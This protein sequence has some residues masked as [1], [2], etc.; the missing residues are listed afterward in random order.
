MRTGIQSKLVILVGL[1][2]LSITATVGTTFYVAS[3]Q[4]SDAA[5][6][7]VAA[8]QRLLAT[9][10]ESSSRELIDALE[11]ESSSEDIKSRLH[12]KMN[13][14]QTSLL[15]LKDGGE[16]FD[17][18]GA[19]IVFPASEGDAHQQL[20]LVKE[21]WSMYKQ[22]LDVL[23]APEVDVTADTFY[24]ALD[25]A[26]SQ[27]PLVQ[28]KSGKAISL[29]KKDSEAKVMLLKSVLVSALVAIL[30][31]AVLAWIYVRRQVVAPLTRLAHTMRDSELNSNLSL[32]IAPGPQDEIG[33]TASNFNR[34]MDKFE[35]ILQQL[36][37]Y[38]A[39]VDV[40][41]VELAKVANR[42]EN[43]VEKQ[44]LEID[45][46]AIAMNE[47]Q[48]SS[49][50]VARN[51]D[52]AAAKANEAQ[53]AASYSD[54]VV[55]RTISAVQE[56]AHSTQLSL[57]LMS[58]LETDVVGIGAI[59]DVIRGIADQ[60][61]LLA[62]NAA[63]EAA[64]AGEQGRGF[65]VVADEVRMLAQRTQNSTQEIQN[66]IEQLQA[67]AT[68]AYDA[69][70]QG[71][72]HA[73]ETS[74]Q[75]ASTGESL[76]QIA[77]VVTEIAGMNQQISIASHQQGTVAIELDRNLSQIKMGA[78]ESADSSQK[79]TAAGAQLAELAVELRAV[80]SQFRLSGPDGR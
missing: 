37:H 22:A 70:N 26:A 5:I 66:M 4:F 44:Q 72:E 79:T 56:Q 61:N 29:L 21:A 43:I 10:I 27:I 51:T 75:A 39:R 40:E 14:F 60:T 32:R 13:L 54:T 33:E 76:Q 16:T 73:E 17:D 36:V 77:N 11:S 46:V 78:E 41:V 68:E 12:A 57:D 19:E 48:A 38:A 74:S 6:I 24:D 23:M 45:Q 58:K 52:T 64:R 1:F 80:V 53:Q 35:V 8:R 69:L 47:M 63:I 67:R 62:L 9:Q 50:E 71:Y 49:Q 34:M 42:T 28:E 15:A 30:T 2:V 3:T 18:A 65:A 7:A 20:A 55:R 25:L 31:I 59:L